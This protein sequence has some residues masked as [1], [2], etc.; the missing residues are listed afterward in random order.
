MPT[1]SN[2]G[3]Q[4]IRNGG[5]GAGA[6]SICQ[7]A[8]PICGGLG[9]IRYDVPV[10]DPRFGKL[11]RCPNNPQRE[12]HSWKDRLRK[13]S[14][15]D[16][17]ADKTFEGFIT[18]SVGY[19]EE[20]QTS[21]N[22]ALNTAWQFANEMR[23]WLLLEGPYGC[24]KTHL[25][26]AVGNYRLS[27]GDM[28][29]FITVPDLLDHLRAAYGPSSEISYDETFERVRE[30]P[31]LILDDL[32]VEN[33]SPWAQE[34]LF[35]LFNDRYTH[36]RATVI[37]TNADVN[38]LDPRIRSRLL[39]NSLMRRAKIVAP[40]FRS[41]ALSE[42]ESIASS[43]TYY[44]DMTFESFVFTPNDTA[45]ERKFLQEKLSRVQQYAEN[46][47]GWLI[48]SGPYGAGKTHLA[49]AVANFRREFGEKVM[50]I[51]V[52]DL[53]DYL[54]FA[55]DPRSK[56]TFDK[57]INEV[58]NIGMLILDDL[59]T[60]NATP[61]AKEK[62]FQILDYRYVRQFPTVITTATKISDLD[63]RIQT[64]IMDDRRA[65]NI[66]LTLRPYAVRR[67]QQG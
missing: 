10:E 63:H 57:R 31:L 54:R 47:T 3:G 11:F 12:D 29:L 18:D 53:L 4:H 65:R 24:G 2:D 22:Y 58:K 64:R 34:K 41:A 39:D 6:C 5:P 27:Q 46:P 32:G 66:A 48:L 36:Q 7:A 9:M 40:D 56:S 16:T 62:L 55:Y 14:N 8:D 59:G 21:L 61:W 17:F 1:S 33:P 13:L 67:R 42:R 60:E 28:V 25:A 35:Q 26:A 51:T 52:P 44:E 30:V 43:L 15:L 20:E 49:A 38:D 19:S 45:E 23:G 50:F 37:T